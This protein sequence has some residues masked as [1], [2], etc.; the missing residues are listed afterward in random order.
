MK[1]ALADQPATPFRI[2]QGIVLSPVDAR[3]GTPVPGGTPG[4]IMEAF[5]PG[6]EPGSNLA[7]IL[8]F[9]GGDASASP[10]PTAVAGRATPSKS[11]EPIVTTIRSGTGG[12]Y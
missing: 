7:G 4:S 5:K 1:E 6:T 11:S 2:P 8:E 12:L 3:T 10:Q 9:G